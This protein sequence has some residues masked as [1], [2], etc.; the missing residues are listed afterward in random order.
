M[1][2]RPKPMDLKDKYD[3]FFPI[4][5]DEE[6]KRFYSLSKRNICM[7]KYFDDQIFKDIGM[8]DF[9]NI[10]CKKLGWYK[11]KTVKYDVFLELTIEFCTTLKI[12]DKEQR[13]FFM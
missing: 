12:K 4:L 7:P 5:S 8:H 9:I 3:A 2:I 1:G 10:L 11:L 6:G 13:I